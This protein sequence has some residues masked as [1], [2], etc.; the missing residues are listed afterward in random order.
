LSAL[1]Q[2]N[3]ALA[4]SILDANRQE[5]GTTSFYFE[6]LG[7]SNELLGNPQTAT[8]AYAKAVSMDPKVARLHFELGASAF[9]AGKSH[10]AVRE[11]KLGLKLEPANK[12]GLRYLIGIYVS[13]K[14]WQ[15]AS[16][17]F[18]SLGAFDHP[19]LLKDPSMV[20]LFARV[21][22][23]TG[24]ASQIDRL[25]P[26]D[27]AQMTSALLFSLGG[28]FAEKKMDSEVIRFLSHIPDSDADDAVYFNLATAYSHV[29]EF[30]NARAQYF[31]AID[32]H[33]GHVE[34]YFHVGLDY[35]SCGQQ[36][37]AVPWLAQAHRLAP[38]RADISFALVE[39]LIHLGY[40]D[41]AETLLTSDDPL[42]LV[43]AGDLKAAQAKNEDA[44]SL[45]R[46]A[47]EKK[48][49]LLEALIGLAAVQMAQEK[50]EE[51]RDS[52]NLALKT[53]PD[54][55]AAEGALGALE[56][57]QSEWSAASVHL[58]DAWKQ[59][60]S[61]AQVGLDLARSLRH[62]GKVEQARDLLVSLK[63][64]LNDVPAYHLELAQLYRQLHQDVESALEQDIFNTIQKTSEASL[65]F[66]RAG[67]Y[68]F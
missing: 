8:E 25:L 48:P 61:N 4:S 58:A 35:A 56:Y 16:Q 9:E 62:S 27:G 45:Y 44:T 21:L 31:H 63:P 60:H 47:L 64:E 46:H 20:L 12:A 29:Q 13:L 3:P 52:L 42:M 1:R 23:E 28:L 15:N 26:A 24:Q 39:Q 37:K 34:A 7:T 38:D 50:Y 55:P 59:S 14:D 22:L 33:P 18:K 49:G 30:D 5:C 36:T 66:N 65:R 51:A 40:S 6:L 67:T 53:Y 17:A 68:V 54:N 57:K 2:K 43:A 41:S 19:D 32:R 11:L 10:D